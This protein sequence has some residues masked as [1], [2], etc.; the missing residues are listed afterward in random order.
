MEK[1]KPNLSR[2]LMQLN[3]KKSIGKAIAK[4]K[5]R[6]II[7]YGVVWYGAPLLIVTLLRVLFFDYSIQ[8]NIK[9]FSIMVFSVLFTGSLASHYL[10][11]RINRIYRN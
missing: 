4:G 11:N 6:F 7:F 10:W 5:L 8:D 2:Y 9:T 3:S 1:N